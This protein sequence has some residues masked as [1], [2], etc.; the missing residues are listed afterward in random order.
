MGGVIMKNVQRKENSC[1]IRNISISRT[2]MPV[3]GI[4][5]LILL[6]G[7]APVMAQEED[8]HGRNVFVVSPL[9]GFDNNTLQSRDMRGQPIELED[10]GL[11]YGLF[12]LFSSKHF[13]VNNFSNIHVSFVY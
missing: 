2:L 8:E 5:L 12:A 3:C 1:R 10:T 11:E 6:L 13:T 4:M 7:I 9:I